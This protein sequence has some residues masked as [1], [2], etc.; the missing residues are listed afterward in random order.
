M[1][2]LKSPSTRAV[3]RIGF[4]RSTPATHHIAHAKLAAFPPKENATR[5]HSYGIGPQTNRPPCSCL[6]IGRRSATYFFAP[7]DLDRRTCCRTSNP[8]M[9]WL[10]PP[11]RVRS[12]ILTYLSIYKTISIRLIY[13]IVRVGQT[14]RSGRPV[15][16]FRSA[17]LSHV[18][19]RLGPV[20]T[21]GPTSSDHVF[22]PY[23]GLATESARHQSPT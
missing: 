11:N 20:S 3:S 1:E 7:P 8:W 22:H 4:E 10:V 14:G 13:K 16:P 23:S 2:I 19:L 21:P 12:I 17:S 15:C 6:G 9:F 5:S 18:V